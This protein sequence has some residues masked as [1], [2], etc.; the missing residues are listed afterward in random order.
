V[1]ALFGISWTA[2]ATEAE[3]SEDVE[4]ATNPECPTARSMAEKGT[5]TKTSQWGFWRGIHR[6]RICDST[7]NPRTRG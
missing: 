3:P 5:L 4:M 6:S 2:V 1:P 7:N